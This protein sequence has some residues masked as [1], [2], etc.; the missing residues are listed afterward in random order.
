MP[1][2]NVLSQHLVNKIA[3]G[4][5]V[6]RPASVVK[7]LL[8]NS[9]DAGAGKITL[10]IEDGGKKLIRVSDDGCG[11]D[12]D[13]IEL[14]YRPHATSKI[15]TN[16]DLFSICTMGFRGEA[17]ASI[18]SVSQMEI[19]SRT[20]DQI[21]GW[22]LACN[23]GDLSEKT[24]A[25][26]SCGTVTTVQNLFFNT[27][28][29]RKFLK[30]NNTEMGHINE[31]FTRITLAHRQIHFVLIH[32]GR[33]LKDLPAD[34]S[35]TQRAATLF[36][37]EL[38]DGLIPVSRNDRGVEISGVI[39]RPQQAR[40]GSQWQY[41]FLNGR[42]IRDK[43]IGHAIREGYR[44]MMEI[45]RQPITFLFIKIDPKTVDVNVH[46]TKIE[47]RFADSNVI[48][49]QVLA[50][51][52]DKLLGSDMAVQYK[53][54]QT[55][56]ATEP[57]EIQR[58]KEEAEERRQRVRAAMA[59]FF[60]KSPVANGNQRQ[61][62][63]NSGYK[64]NQGVAEQVAAGGL[65]ASH[66]LE[67]TTSSPKVVQP[68]TLNT[69]SGP[70][71]TVETSDEPSADV[72]YKTGTDQ[73]SEP[74]GRF[75]QIHNSY[76]VEQSKEGLDIIDQHAL[77]ERALYEKLYDQLNDGPLVAQRYLIPEVIDVTPAQ[78]AAVETHAET[79]KSLGVEA[80]QF[81]PGSVA[82]Q[83]FPVLLEKASPGAFVSDLLDMLVIQAGRV[84]REELMHS[85]LDMMACKAAVKAGDYLTED[86]I[87]NLLAYRNIVQRSGNCPH[88]RPT[89]IK[90]SLNELEKLF[91]R[92]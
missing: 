88:G 84:T 70:V 14:A 75:L 8:E 13:D 3:A 27:P 2:I 47:V 51:V 65:A 61:M 9:I 43:F 73:P 39:A 78:L 50:A 60:K 16:D 20:K 53:G 69:Q 92:T 40:S 80:E 19:V 44:G 79:L 56:S 37:T 29:R 24:P 91:K 11:M 90:L 72:A 76:I 86:E 5:V 45:N 87:K 42:Y 34:Q 41:V 49:S 81:G 22:R 83:A 10:E 15:K 21:E 58:T 89:T 57:D 18:A 64:N 17:M 54:S 33:K 6:E 71:E 26:A 35:L 30:T 85:I 74:V 1:R 25:A 82:V 55:S 36:S 63:F 52:R 4:E 38:A 32:N 66:T 59:D 23:G 67:T 28:A 77:H 62:N 48:H 7:E 12:G 68:P 46:P 31:Q